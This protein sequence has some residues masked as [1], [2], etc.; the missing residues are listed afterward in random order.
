MKKIAIDKNIC[1]ILGIAFLLLI[2]SFIS[3]CWTDESLYVEAA[4]MILQGL[5][6]PSQIFINL[7][8]IP[9]VPIL[10]VW[11]KIF[12]NEG[13]YLLFRIV[14][15]LVMLFAA[16]KTYLFLKERID[17]RKACL[18]SILLLIYSRANIM[19][20]SYYNL[21]LFFFEISLIYFLE[22]V[23]DNKNTFRA[24]V[25]LCIFGI[26]SLL[27]NP[28]L[29]IIH[30]FDFLLFINRKKTRMISRSLVIFLILCLVFYI[31]QKLFPNTSLIAGYTLDSFFS[32]NVSKGIEYINLI[33]L[34]YYSI[35][36]FFII[37]FVISLIVRFIKKDNAR[38]VVLI[39]TI[40]TIV[41]YS[42]I[43]F[44]RE[45]FSLG[46][47]YIWFVFYFVS[48]SPLVLVDGYKPKTEYV[49]TF[50]DGILFSYFFHLAS[51]TQIQAIGIGMVIATIGAYLIISESPIVSNR[52]NKVLIGFVLL[53]LLV[54]TLFL[55]LF[56]VYRD[57]NVWEC[58]KLIDVGPAKGLFTT[59]EH[60]DQYIEVMDSMKYISGKDKYLLVS[61]I[62]PWSYLCTDAKCI[63]RLCW[64]ADMD[65]Q[66]LKDF[67]E[68]TNNYPD[69]IL[70]LDEQYGSYVDNYIWT[71]AGAADLTP[72]AN[73]SEGWLY[74]FINSEGM[75][76]MKVPAGVLYYFE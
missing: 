7:W 60:Y 38:L 15:L 71:W 74:D 46:D 47:T 6:I 29:G 43:I 73:V 28:F 32:L 24:W 67:C 25:G 33:W 40:I 26:L 61:K 35:I 52:F 22:I 58:T 50:I 55:R 51:N 23:I 41:M 65:N 18:A 75:K 64:R 30:I 39:A 37:N 9:A 56:G 5:Q 44:K 49:I 48:I 59:Q 20:C 21:G 17:A 69:Y 10:F 8:A 31:V 19:G 12:G 72:N 53:C 63:T 54:N 16:I 62:A 42:I 70:V 27:V 66:G 45:F 68:L 2:R 13:V 34:S 4:N 76:S 3:F 11:Q 1:I 14:M 36:R 57:A